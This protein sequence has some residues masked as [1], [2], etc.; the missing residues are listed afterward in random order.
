VRQ[1][2]ATENLKKLNLNMRKIFFLFVL[3][4]INLSC[5]SKFKSTDRKDS[6]IEKNITRNPNLGQ[7]ICWDCS[8]E[9]D[10]LI[11][12]TKIQNQIKK[13]NFE[14]DSN[15]NCKEYSKKCT[16]YLQNNIPILITEITTGIC[17][18]EMSGI[19]KKTNKFQILKKESKISS[20]VE[21]YINN[22]EKFEI[23]VL[24]ASKFDYDLKVKE[25]YEKIINGILEQ[26]K[27]K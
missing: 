22:W 9:I 1:F 16:I 17:E 11:Y 14:I 20:D 21:I 7:T 26:E 24:G 18:Y 12:F 5:S 15:N 8:P 2:R 25:K 27:L 19:N 10:A 3:I 23:T 13:I 6:K 4:S